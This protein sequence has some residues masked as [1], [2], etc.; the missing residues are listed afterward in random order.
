MSCTYNGIVVANSSDYDWKKGGLKLFWFGAYGTTKVYAWGYW[1]DALEAAA[2]WLKENAP[3]H[4][5]DPD[6][7]EAAL[8]LGEPLGDADVANVD[9]KWYP[10]EAAIELAETDM[11][12][13]ESGWLTSYEFGGR[14]CDAE[15]TAAVKAV[16]A[17]ENEDE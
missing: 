15:E 1:E 4:L 14:D 12:Y 3:G 7:R 13:T 9:G 8:E 2:E 6:Y 17:A 10:S 11:T 5:S 16:C